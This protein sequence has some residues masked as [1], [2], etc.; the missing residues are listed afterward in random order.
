MNWYVHS[1]INS[2]K[3]SDV[4]RAVDGCCDHIELGKPAH[5]VGEQDSFGPVTRFLECVE[6]H[7]AAIKQQNEEE[8]HCYDCRKMVKQGNTI[9]WRWYDFYAPQGDEPLIICLDCTKLPTHQQRVAKDRAD[10]L[11][12]LHGDSSVDEDDYY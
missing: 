5:M 8:V 7:E 2:V 9:R 4:D 11:A 10:M 12:E 6:C 3:P 1:L